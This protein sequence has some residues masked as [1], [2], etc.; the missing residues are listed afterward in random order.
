MPRITNYEGIDDTIKEFLNSQ[1]KSTAT[2]YLCFFRKIVDYYKMSGKELLESKKAD[3]G[4]EWERKIMSFIGW[5]KEQNYSDNAC[6]TAINSLRSF[7]AYYRVPFEFT[8]AETKKLGGKPK[9]TTKDYMLVNEDISKM[10]FVGDLREKYVLLLGKSLGFRAGDFA[11]FTYGAFRSINLN[12]EAPIFIGE[13]VTEKE[14]V[15]AYPFIDSDAL[16][17]VKAMLEGNTDKADTE[18]IFPIL[19]RELSTILQQLADKANINLGDKHLR[20]HCLRKYLIDRLSGNM[21]E[22]KWKQ[23]VGKAT[24][25]DAYVS[26]FELKECY[27][28][29]MK[30]TTCILTNGNGKVS[31]LS[32]EVTKLT[33]RISLLEKQNFLSKATIALIARRFNMTTEELEHDI[34]EEAQRQEQE[35]E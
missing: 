23:I 12:Q 6:K 10:A 19:E 24:S 35:P 29:V 32:E 26:S 28:K 33:A 15:T 25:E 13:T 21:S 8:T 5:M 22:S 1:K 34:E 14:G 16:P 2:I 30:L 17:V 3:K 20:F 4:F 11:S 31:K 27:S 7:F 18:R 9:R